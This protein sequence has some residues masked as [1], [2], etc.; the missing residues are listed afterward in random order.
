MGYLV[1][2]PT[3]IIFNSASLNLNGEYGLKGSNSATKSKETRN[4]NK[5]LP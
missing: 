1:Q 5:I 3:L 4:I 2:I